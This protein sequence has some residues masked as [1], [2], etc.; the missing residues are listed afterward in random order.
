[1]P[2]EVDEFGFCTKCAVCEQGCQHLERNLCKRSPHF[3]T[4]FQAPANRT[5]NF[6][7]NS[8]VKKFTMCTYNVSFNVKIDNLVNFLREEPADIICIQEMVH[9]QVNLLIKC[10]KISRQWRWTFCARSPGCQSLILSTFP[11]EEVCRG[12]L[13]HR[14]RKWN[15][16]FVTVKVQGFYLTSLHLGNK[17]E[18]TRLCQLNN[19][20]DR[21][22]Q[23]GVWD[24]GKMHILAGDFN[25]LTKEDKSQESW[26]KV[27]AER[28]LSTTKKLGDK[29]KLE[30]PKFDLTASMSQKDFLDMWG[31]ET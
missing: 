17:N 20:R 7:Y 19:L 6:E 21:L 29:T 26:D 8:N 28:E 23:K 5:R 10:L 4:C 2:C 30:E 11:L 25:S 15:R 1:M 22:S 31:G 24:Q 9:W 13:G 14:G 27:A 16:Q 12:Y 18:A 3:N